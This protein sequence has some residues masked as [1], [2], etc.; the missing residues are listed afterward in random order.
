MNGITIIIWA[1][2]FIIGAI[3]IIGVKIR[4]K[5][6]K[7]ETDEKSLISN[8]K[9]PGLF[10]FERTADSNPNQLSQSPLSYDIPEQPAEKYPADEVE[11]DNSQN[12]EYESQNQVLINY[13]KEVKRFQE[14]M[15]Q[16]QI[17]IMTSNNDQNNE[18]HELKDLFT[19]DELIKESKR[20]DT[21]RE[22]ESQR[23]QTEAE[24]TTEIKESIRKKQEQESSEEKLIEE[25]L[26]DDET[27]E[28][29]KA[30][31]SESVETIQDII[32]SVEAEKESSEE[33]IKDIIENS[34]SEKETVQESIDIKE[35]AVKTPAETEAQEPAT[36]KDIAEAIS[37]ASQEIGEE[38]EEIGISESEGITDAVLKSEESEEI[39]QPTLK[40]PTKIDEIKQQTESLIYDNDIIT[41]KQED[42]DLDYRKDLAKI[43]NTIK[44]SR[45][46]QDVKERI[47][48]TH[49]PEVIDPIVDLE[50]SYIRTVDYDDEYAPIIN[51]THDEF[52]EEYEPFYDR[53]AI[54]EEN[55][56]RL[57][58]TEN[59]SP[60][61]E[62]AKPTIEP[63]KPKPERDNI[64]IKMGNADMVLKKGDEIIFNYNGDT[65]SSQ[66][67]AINGDDISVRYRRKD[68]TI[69][70]EDVKKIYLLSFLQKHHTLLFF[71]KTT[72]FH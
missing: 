49:E 13:E 71:N 26:T 51:E 30:E 22:K 34:K 4:F 50:E 45:L 23:I 41:P 48:P 35:T 56:R 47:I 1:A 40:S 16:N 59:K 38:K 32:D 52:G 55:T 46:F 37:T 64:K 10:S 3:A 18:K 19:I 54:R 65:Y 29:P 24:D 36:Q 69:K 70:P 17:D 5:D 20:K 7:I 12:I 43:T 14:P 72:L 58:G 15:T 27:K 63:I 9:K 33:S 67:Y 39:K 11:T 2:I 44:G 21:E 57:M 6:N 25:V 68:I 60:K 31:E 53:D 28:T 62:V 66:V 42:N 8:E 61:S